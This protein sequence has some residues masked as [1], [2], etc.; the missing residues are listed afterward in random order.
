MIDY[1]LIYHTLKDFTKLIYGEAFTLIEKGLVK[2][3]TRVMFYFPMSSTVIYFLP[4]MFHLGCCIKSKTVFIKVF[5]LLPFSL[6][7]YF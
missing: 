7:N 3:T 5:N 4:C 2:N 1:D 6:S